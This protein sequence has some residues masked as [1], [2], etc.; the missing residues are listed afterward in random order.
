MENREEYNKYI[1]YKKH[2]N[3]DVMDIAER[4]KAINRTTIGE[5]YCDG[6]KVM[7]EEYL[8]QDHF[9]K[10]Y[11]PSLETLLQ[12]RDFKGFV[13]PIVKIIATKLD[14][15]FRIN[16]IVTDKFTSRTYITNIRSDGKHVYLST[17][18]KK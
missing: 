16:Q 14:K 7:K 13:L 18:I 11:M 9:I 6:Q 17:E 1:L 5:Y 8:L 4:I 3:I 2:L 10:E 15:P 12:D